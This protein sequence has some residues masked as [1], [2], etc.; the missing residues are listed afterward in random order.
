[1]RQILEDCLPEGVFETYLSNANGTPDHHHRSLIVNVAC[2]ASVCQDG[3]RSELLNGYILLYS[4]CALLTYPALYRHCADV[5]SL[6]NSATLIGEVSAPLCFFLKYWVQTSSDYEALFGK[7]IPANWAGIHRPVLS[8]RGHKPERY[9]VYSK[10]AKKKNKEIPITP[11][12]GGD[13]HI[14]ITKFDIAEP[15]GLVVTC[16][17]QCGWPMTS[18]MHVNTVRFTCNCGAKGTVDQYKTS[19]DTAL[20]SASL[21]AVRF[22]QARYYAKWDAPSEA[23]TRTGPELASAGIQDAVVENGPAQDVLAHVEDSAVQDNAI[24]ESNTGTTRRRSTRKR[25]PTPK[26][27]DPDS[28]STS[29]P[30]KVAPTAKGKRKATS[31]QLSPPPMETRSSSLPTIR[32]PPYQ[33]RLE[34]A[35]KSSS[36]AL[37]LHRSTPSGTSGSRSVSSTPAPPSPLEGPESGGRSSPLLTAGL[38]RKRPRYW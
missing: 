28:R 22:P 11:P 32:V 17:I 4:N 20:G 27:F 34:L 8:R 18:S 14:L 21:V 3:A 19:Q 24:E 12:P 38:I 1:V 10:L 16:P 15:C 23:D 13:D 6:A 7:A 35:R 5:L 31:R 9:T 29:P 30:P 2:G 36:P 25:K 33:T 26:A 37:S